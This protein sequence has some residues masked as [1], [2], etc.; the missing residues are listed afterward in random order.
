MAETPLFTAPELEFA[1]SV[2]LRFDALGLP[3]IGGRIF[4]LLVVSPRPLS[5]DEIASVLGISRASVSINTRLFIANG[6]MEIRA[7]PG[8]RRQYY[9]MRKD[10]FFTRLPFVRG[11]LAG[12]KALAKEAQAAVAEGAKHRAERGERVTG[13]EPPAAW[14]TL[15]ASDAPGPRLEQALQFIAF[16]EAQLAE[17]EARFRETFGEQP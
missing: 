5:L 15:R 4:G 14:G 17:I 16:V 6:S 10:V 1:E 13:A 3:R 7:V 2:G 12:V 9:A 11:A 8:D